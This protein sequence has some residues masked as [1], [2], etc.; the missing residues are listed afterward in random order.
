MT[1]PDNNLDM[2]ALRNH[3]WS[4]TSLESEREHNK[5]GTSILPNGVICKGLVE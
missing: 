5:W 3:S 1:F 4:L 2:T